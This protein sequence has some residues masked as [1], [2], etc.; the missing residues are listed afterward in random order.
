MGMKG[1][2]NTKQK[3]PK[4]FQNPSWIQFANMLFIKAK[5]VTKSCTSFGD[6]YWAWMGGEEDEFN[7]EIND[8]NTLGNTCKQV[9]L[10][11]RR[12]LTKEYLHGSIIC[13]GIYNFILNI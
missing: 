2:K 10:V 7:F 4:G 3:N 6:H 1:D 5:H 11:I 9:N 12:Q 8:A 13:C